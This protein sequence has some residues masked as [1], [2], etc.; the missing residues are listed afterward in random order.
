MERSQDPGWLFRGLK[1][2]IKQNLAL[3]FGICS[4]QVRKRVDC[5]EKQTLNTVL[6]R[7]DSDSYFDKID[8]KKRENLLVLIG[9]V[10][11]IAKSPR[12]VVFSAEIIMKLRFSFERLKSRKKTYLETPGRARC[13]WLR[14]FFRRKNLKILFLNHFFKFLWKIFLEKIFFCLFLHKILRLRNLYRM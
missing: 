10:I 14:C 3:N 2:R 4:F 12:R 11:L 1:L 13:S 8:E 9:E 7:N 5:F 6:R